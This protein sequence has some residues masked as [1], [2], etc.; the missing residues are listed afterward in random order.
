M[1][2]AA[3]VGTAPAKPN[4]TKQVSIGTP[5]PKA[6]MQ[7]ASVHHNFTQTSNSATTVSK[8]KEHNFKGYGGQPMNG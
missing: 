8:T 7:R 5:K 3:S 2:V 4:E 6:A 1:G